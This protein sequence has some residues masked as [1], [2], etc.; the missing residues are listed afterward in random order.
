MI[1]LDRYYLHKYGGL[2]FTLYIA[3][4]TATK[5]AVVVYRHVYPFESKV[6]VRPVAEWADRFTPI[7][8]YKAHEIMLDVDRVELQAQIKARKS[9]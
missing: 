2:Y 8:N 6:Y 9:S 3:E 4:D 5:D 7:P 1:E